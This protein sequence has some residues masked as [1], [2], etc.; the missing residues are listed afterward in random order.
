MDA[1]AAAHKGVSPA[2]G[3]T[4]V[5]RVLEEAGYRRCVGRDERGTP[6]SVVQALLQ[7]RFDIDPNCLGKVLRLLG[8]EKYDFGPF[9]GPLRFEYCV[10]RMP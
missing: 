5:V 9:K 4:E 3:F 7:P 1:A 2:G 8:V 6:A 10:T